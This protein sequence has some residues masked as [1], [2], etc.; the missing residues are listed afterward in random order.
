MHSNDVR[1]NGFT[2]VSIIHH[3]A[4]VAEVRRAAALKYDAAGLFDG[5]LQL[6]VT[7]TLRWSGGAT[8]LLVMH[9]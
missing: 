3:P 8:P 7:L 9:S 1:E 4:A 5:Y 6:T 2:C